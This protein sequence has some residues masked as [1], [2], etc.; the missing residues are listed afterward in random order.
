MAPE[1]FLRGLSDL[2]V[3]AALIFLPNSN[4]GLVSTAYKTIHQES[5]KQCQIA[6]LVDARPTFGGMLGRGTP[7][8]RPKRLAQQDSIRQGLEPS[9][10]LALA[11]NPASTKN[12]SSSV[13]R[14]TVKA[15]EKAELLYYFLPPNCKPCQ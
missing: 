9:W 2:I 5:W 13:F 4:G 15:H 3:C 6:V 14:T 11:I 8:I 10:P 7:R 12:F 1:T